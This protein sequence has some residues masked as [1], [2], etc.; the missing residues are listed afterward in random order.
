MT[1]FLLSFF[2]VSIISITTMERPIMHRVWNGG[3][4]GDGDDGDNEDAGGK[5]YSGQWQNDIKRGR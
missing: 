5:S 2:L 3:D 1:P 4:G